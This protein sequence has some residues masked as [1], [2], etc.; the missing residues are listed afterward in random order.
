M[1]RP[2]FA[3]EHYTNI[4]QAKMIAKQYGGELCYHPS[5]G[6]M[7]Y[8]G[9]VWASDDLKTRSL[10]QHFASEQVREA[11]E[12]A[13]N[14]IIAGGRQDNDY[15]KFALHMCNTQ[16]IDNTLKELQPMLSIDINQLDRDPN[17]LCTPAG[18]LDLRAG[19]SSMRPNA[20]SDHITKRTACS[21]SEQ[22]MELW[23]QALNTIFVG[24][25]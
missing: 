21:P 15:R 24:D 5:T 23:Q 6:F 3:P 8:N 17:L 13:A 4:D 18:T 20:S 7:H 25:E 12:L 22:G 14:A 16:Q 10:V 2:V 19:L 9:L 1:M 11:N